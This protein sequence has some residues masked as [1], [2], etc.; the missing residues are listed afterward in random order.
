MMKSV[1]RSSSEMI[2][3]DVFELY[4][5][6]TTLKSLNCPLHNPQCKGGVVYF[7]SILDALSTTDAAK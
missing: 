1:P 7:Q 6:P 5:H 4:G 2:T 3:V